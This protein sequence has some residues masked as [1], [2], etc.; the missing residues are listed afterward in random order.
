MIRRTRTTARTSVAAARRTRPAPV[1]KIDYAEEVQE[2]LQTIANLERQ[3]EDLQ[4]QKAVVEEEIK[5]YYTRSGEELI[6]DG[7]YEVKKFTPMGR[8]STLIDPQ[9]F[10]KF[11][12]DEAFWKCCKIGVTEAREFVSEKEMQKV[13]TIVPGKAGKPEIVITKLKKKGK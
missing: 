5:E 11:A 1:P 13:A 2:R 7:I 6:S 4:R 9:K 10:K 12:G 3:M 8:S